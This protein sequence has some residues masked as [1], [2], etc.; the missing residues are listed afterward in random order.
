MKGCRTRARRESTRPALPGLTS[1]RGRAASLPAA[2]GPGPRG[3]PGRPRRGGHGE[4][5]AGA[6]GPPFPAAAL[7]RTS[8]RRSLRL[9]PHHLSGLASLAGSFSPRLRLRLWDSLKMARRE[10]PSLRGV[11]AA[12]T[13][14]TG[15]AGDSQRAA[16]DGG[17]GHRSPET[18]RPDGERPRRPLT[19]GKPGTSADAS[20][21]LHVGRVR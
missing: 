8:G 1:S 19:A 9:R 3:P 2:P 17:A 16:A 21:D 14:V 7:T 15:P 11:G 6:P 13:P 10:G 12:V 18:Q 20:G 5:A 4:D